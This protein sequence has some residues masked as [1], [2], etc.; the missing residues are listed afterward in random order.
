MP[1]VLQI[2]KNRKSKRRKI[3]SDAAARESKCF[4]SPGYGLTTDVLIALGLFFKKLKAVGSRSI[5]LIEEFPCN[6]WKAI[7]LLITACGKSKDAE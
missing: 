7:C 4:T 6:F 1:F 2:I 5:G 3:V